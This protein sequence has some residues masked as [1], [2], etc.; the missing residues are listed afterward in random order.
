MKRFNLLLVNNEASVGHLVLKTLGKVFRNNFVFE[1]STLDEAEKIMGKLQINL[2]L[3]DLDSHRVDLREY[4]ERYPGSYV[5]G[6]HSKQS[7]VPSVLEPFRNKIIRKETLGEELLS[8][9]R[10]IRKEWADQIPVGQRILRGPNFR[11]LF[12]MVPG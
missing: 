8:D 7:S 11:D 9:F 10:G 1:V 12:R 4:C 3:V 2:L 5:M 6:Y